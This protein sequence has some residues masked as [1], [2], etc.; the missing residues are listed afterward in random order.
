M[1]VL[2]QAMVDA[3]AAGVAFTAHPVTGDREQTVLTAVAGLGD[4]LVSGAAVG[5]EWTA[6]AGAV[7]L[8]RPLPDGGPVLT[9]GQA[10]AI[11]DL[12]HQVGERYRGP[13]DIEW[14]IDQRGRLWLLQARPMTAVPEPVSWVGGLGAGAVDAQLPTR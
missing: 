9:A 3:V 13:Q 10:Q 2:V 11:A 5:E 4:P 12:G 7:R 6:T 1:A 14:A 8:T